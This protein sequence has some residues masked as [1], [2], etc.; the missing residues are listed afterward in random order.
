MI[1]SIINKI[2]ILKKKIRS[3]KK[4]YSFGGADLL[5][6]YIFKYQHE[7]FYL[8]IGCQHPISNN[9]T[10]LLH[11]KGWSGINIDLDE[12]NVELFKLHRP[13]DYNIC[14]CISSVNNI[15]DLYF[16]HK[17]SPINTLESKTILN[18]KN[19]TIKKISTVTL[20]SVLENID[21]PHIDFMNLDVEG[22]EIDVLNGFN[23]NLYKPKV[24]CVE[25][26]DY[27]L[28]KLEFKNNNLDNV[29][30][31]KL[32]KYFIDHNYHFV[33]WNHA[34]LIFVHSDFRD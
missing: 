14:S 10:Y 25:Y 20:N 32:Y 19:Y 4:S 9:N 31:S 28:N 21:I 23:I 22:H 15:K 13:K 33:N 11:K 27:K 26:L 6:K 2:S 24:I 3:E 16:F 1:S 12:K 5:V 34:D 18:K 29:L 7:G 30:N 17:G 8:D